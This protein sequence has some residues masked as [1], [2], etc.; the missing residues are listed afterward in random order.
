MLISFFKSDDIIRTTP[1]IFTTAISSG[2]LSHHALS[3]SDHHAYFVHFNATQLFA[4]PAYDLHSLP[5]CHIWLEDPRLVE[6]YTSVL[7]EQLKIHKVFDKSSP[8]HNRGIL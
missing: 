3:C 5:S 1:G 6:Q 4:D 8:F 7:H 2:S